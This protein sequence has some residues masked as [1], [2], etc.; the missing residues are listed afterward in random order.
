LFNSIS[1]W[2]N[3]CRS[4]TTPMGEKS[5]SSYNPP[6]ILNISSFIM[7]LG[8]RGLVLFISK[9]THLRW[10]ENKI[11]VIIKWSSGSNLHVGRVIRS[12]VPRHQWVGLKFECAV[13]GLIEGGKVV[14]AD[15]GTVYTRPVKTITILLSFWV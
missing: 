2:K 15:C 6:R 1:Q 12:P 9:E 8:W 10:T 5:S 3:Y 7:D 11:M 14:R 13:E 4:D